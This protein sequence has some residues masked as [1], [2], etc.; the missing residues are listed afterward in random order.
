MD[1]IKNLERIL[2]VNETN[3]LKDSV[4]EKELRIR[5]AKADSQI[6]KM[7]ELEV[8]NSL[9]IEETDYVVQSANMRAAIAA[10]EHSITFP[11]DEMDVNLRLG[12]GSLAMFFAS[13][14]SGKS[15]FVANAAYYLAFVKKKKVL[16]IVNEESTVDVGARISC[17]HRGHSIHK[18][19]RGLQVYPQST[20]DEISDLTFLTGKINIQDASVNE[21]RVR[22]FEGVMNLIDK[23]KLSYDAIFIDYYQNIDRSLTDPLMNAFEAQARFASRVDIAKNT[24]KCPIILMGQIKKNE[25]DFEERIKGRKLIVDKCT[26]VFELV[27]EKEK[28]RTTMKIHKDRWGG[29]QG[30]EVYLGYEDG[31]L[32]F[33]ND[34]FEERALEKQRQ[35]ID[36][37]FSNNSSEQEDDE[38]D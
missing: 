25:A 19:R 9:Q 32:K 29:K 13:T 12:P 28:S 34:D 17:L 3:K 8:I 30:E 27:V 5:S 21:G 16:I 6:E 20:L 15:T 24:A 2:K 10:R 18:F 26:D 1:D 4:L 7:A 36:A 14:G 33:Y 23:A 38:D 37:K 35:Y 11:F 31:F 22:S